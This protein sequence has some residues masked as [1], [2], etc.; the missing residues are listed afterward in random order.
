MTRV[1]LRPYSDAD[2]G[3]TVA[4]EADAVVKRDLGGIVEAEEA[5]RIHRDRL[6]RMGNG[7]LFYTIRV[8]GCEEPIGIAAVFA[9]P[10]EG[11]TIYEAGIMLLPGTIGQ[12]IGLE[13][14]GRLAERAR[15]ELGL[16]RLDG[17]TAVT[18]IGGNTI[19]RKL[20][21]TLLGECDLDYEGRPIR[22]NHWTLDLRS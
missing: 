10:W 1:E 22:C 4:I 7:E 17:F 15:A 14:L 12:G 9:T 19:C 8:D 11:A 16:E 20:G 5:E 13:T 21:W 2:L 6:E 18:N 3:L